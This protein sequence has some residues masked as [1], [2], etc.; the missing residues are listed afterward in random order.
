MGSP[1]DLLHG[2]LDVLVLKT[3]SWGAMHG[4]GIA[5]WIETHTGGVLGIE[6]AALY[7]CLHRLM[8]AG[9]ID[10]EWGISETNRKARFYRLTPQG[11]A[12]LRAESRTWREF[13]GAIFQV[14]DLA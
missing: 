9:A 1:N 8:R 3:L 10:A 14:L 13:A 11:R 4:Y 5:R 6:D 12:Q 2:T 7:K